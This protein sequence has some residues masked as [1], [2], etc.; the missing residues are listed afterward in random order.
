MHRKEKRK[1]IAVGNFCAEWVLTLN[2]PVV[3]CLTVT[4]RNQ[5]HM[6][7]L[8]FPVA[9]LVQAS[10]KAS[11]LPLGFSS[12]NVAGSPLSALLCHSYP[13]PAKFPEL[14]CVCPEGMS[15][16]HIAPQISV[17]IGRDCISKEWR[18]EWGTRKKCRCPLP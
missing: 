1:L 8:L 17:S 6:L 11:F 3:S 4:P 9:P 13:T 18:V 7:L 16:P 15:L 12:S 2:V 10:C 5:R 14:T